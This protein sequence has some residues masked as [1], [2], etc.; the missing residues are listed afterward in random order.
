VVLDESDIRPQRLIPTGTLAQHVAEIFTVVPKP[1]DNIHVGLPQGFA[2]I[3]FRAFRDARSELSGGDLHAVG[4][5]PHAFN[6]PRERLPITLV[7]RFRPGGAHT[8]FRL[9][10]RELTDSVVALDELWGKTARDL[11]DRILE[12]P[13]TG[14][15]L[16]LVESA[17]EDRLRHM[18]PARPSA[19]S[20]VTLAQDASAGSAPGVARMARDMGIGERQLLRQF[21][22][23]VGLSP[24]L[25]AR[26]ARFE[27]TMRTAELTG[28]PDWSQLAL[29]AGYCDQA[30]LI[31]ECRKL[32]GTN[33]RA[34]LTAWARS[35][36]D[37]LR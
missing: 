14:R 25:Y 16:R 35:R 32:T 20:L 37:G 36:Q 12:T 11:L 34:F 24:K 27:R 26:I 7:V 3:V 18:P 10:M 2:D 30:H 13:S 33:P 6:V 19:M 31:R 21:L 29:E 15:W 8:F 22:E 5:Q 17:L 28:V 9:P 4:A 1:S 23:V